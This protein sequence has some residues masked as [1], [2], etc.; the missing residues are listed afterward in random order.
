M[1]DLL[2][3]EP[4]TQLTIF[5]PTRASRPYLCPRCALCRNAFTKCNGLC[6]K[7]RPRPKVK[8]ERTLVEMRETDNE[9]ALAHYNEIQ[10][11]YEM[12]RTAWEFHCGRPIKERK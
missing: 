10:H 4:R 5:N 9:R 6:H 8:D 3:R 2:G 12:E 1:T 7:P 11:I